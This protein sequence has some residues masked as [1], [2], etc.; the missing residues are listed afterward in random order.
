MFSSLRLENFKAFGERVDIPFAPITLIFGE[1]SAGKSSILQALSLLK[2]TRESRE[3]GVPLLPRVEKGIV[4]LGSF[5]DFIF[6]HDLDR[7]LSIGINVDLPSGR[8]FGSGRTHLLSAIMERKAGLE[9]NFSR[10]TSKSEVSLVE[11]KVLSGDNNAAIAAFESTKTSTELM[12]Q[13]AIRYV[14]FSRE[15]LPKDL[16]AAKCK[17]ITPDE[18][19]W[20][21]KYDFWTEARTKALPKI[22]GV[23]EGKRRPSEPIFFRLDRTMDSE[24]DRQEYQN[25]LQQMVSF[26]SKQFTLAE[27]RDRLLSQQLGIVIGLDGFVPIMAPPRSSLSQITD[28]D[29]LESFHTGPRFNPATA[30]IG[31]IAVAAGTMVDEEFRKLFPMGP[32]RRSPE[33]WY[34]FT[35]TSPQ[36]VGYQGDSMPDFLFRNPDVVK[37]VNSWLQRLE[38]GYRLETRLLGPRIRDLFEV[39]LTDTRRRKSVKVGLPDVGFG[40]SQLLPFIVQALATEGQIISIEQPEVHVHPRL[41]ADIGDLLAECAKR[42]GNQFLIETHSEHLVLRLQKL[43]REGPLKPDDVSIIYVTRG[44]EGSRVQRLALDDTGDFIDEWPGGFFPERLRELS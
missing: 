25:R 18:S 20:K 28:E 22:K 34:I 6:D 32:S 24:Q 33:R 14:R 39:Q 30:D 41:Q 7:S 8:A 38:I 1:N 19:F 37:K 44:S 17:W 13:H 42:L 4:D 26:Y 35:G 3:A 21:R 12:R 9:V 10:P 27:L 36:D 2:Q 29:L 5:H 16:K 23:I 40:I 43:I 15:P 31:R 11:L